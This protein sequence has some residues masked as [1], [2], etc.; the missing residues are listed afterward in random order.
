MVGDLFFG[1]VGL[2]RSNVQ[3]IVDRALAGSDDGEL[4]LEF[5]RSESFSFDDGRLK[6][7][8]FDTTSLG[9]TKALNFQ[10]R[11]LNAAGSP[12]YDSYISPLSLN[13]TGLVFDITNHLP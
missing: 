7:A 10:I 1:K 4:F 3:A 5:C 9:S 12:T 11:A 8:S 6:A 2:D 13:N